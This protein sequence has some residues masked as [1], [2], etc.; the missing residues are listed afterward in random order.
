[1]L[2]QRPELK[3]PRWSVH[4]EMI[5]LLGSETVKHFDAL[6]CAGGQT[7][8]FALRSSGMVVMCSS[9]AERQRLWID[10]GPQGAGRAVH[11]HADALSVQ[12]AVDGKDVLIDSGTFAYAD[13]C[14]D[15]SLFRETS[16][17][18]TVQVD[19]KSQ[20]E[21]AGPFLWRGL[22]DAKP[23]DWVTG[24]SFDLFTGSHRG[25][26]RLSS[27]VVHRRSVF[28]LKPH[29]WL[30]RDVLEGTGAHLAEVGW[31]F[32]PGSLARIPGGVW[33]VGKEQGTATFFCA[34][35]QNCSTEISSGW[36]SPVYGSREPAPVFRVRC[37]TQLPVEFVALLVPRS[38]QE[39]LLAG[40][41]ALPQGGHAAVQGYRFHLDDQIHHVFFSAAPGPWRLGPCRS[42]ARFAYYS[43][44]LDGEIRQYATCD[45]SF[46]E[47]EGGR[48]FSSSKPVAVKEHCAANGPARETASHRPSTGSLRRPV[49]TILQ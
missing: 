37:A 34:G 46:L 2:F 44:A 36:Y 23:D 24:Q 39:T 6:P 30:I 26:T 22:A 4:P 42:D 17:H 29:C 43:A 38:Y 31:H 15:R 16:A 5:W 3:T 48:F 21:A 12:V 27:P 13:A 20:A 19:G 11:G 25:Y 32:A 9:Q 49:P 40:L 7:A 8:S 10:A 33:F 41:R 28:Y 47:V 18:S 45:A 14:G 35:S 1:V